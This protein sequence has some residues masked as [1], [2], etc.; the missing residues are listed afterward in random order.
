[1]GVARPSFEKGGIYHV[2]NRGVAKQDIFTTDRDRAHFLEI[3]SFYRDG[4]FDRRL[5]HLSQDQLLEVLARDPEEP[6]VEILAYCLMPNHFHLVL[7]DLVGGGVSTFLRR[8][9][10][11]YVHYFNTKHNRV[12]PLFQGPYQIVVVRTDEQLL[13]VSRYL[14]LN[15]VVARLCTEPSNYTW[16]SMSTYS[17]GHTSRLCQSQMILALSGSGERYEAFVRDYADYAISLHDYKD[18]LLDL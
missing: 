12:G 3:L 5:S 8:A 4:S 16:S 11:S 2:Y 9:L 1:M 6:L 18:L 10:N 17:S 14:H 7:R 13:H 15:P